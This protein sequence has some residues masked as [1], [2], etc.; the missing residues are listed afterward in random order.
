MLMGGV[1]LRPKSYFLFLYLLQ[2][3]FGL[4]IDIKIRYYS[5]SNKSVKSVQVKAGG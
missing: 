5:F 4:N 1:N 2:S 3:N